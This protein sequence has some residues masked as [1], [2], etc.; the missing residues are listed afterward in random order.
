[1]VGLEYVSDKQ[2]LVFGDINHE[3]YMTPNAMGLTLNNAKAVTMLPVGDLARAQKFYEETLGLKLVAAGLS[4]PLNPG[5]LYEAGA[6]TQ[7]YLFQRAPTRADHT[8]ISFLVEDIE[9][10]VSEL[11]AKNIAFLEYDTPQLKTVNSIAQ[12][13]ALKGAWFND[14]EGNNIEIAQIVDRR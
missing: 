3:R 10:V 11:K 5:A 14:T 2:A 8:V 4:G 1:M 13:G 7:I 12:F 9:K 6:Q